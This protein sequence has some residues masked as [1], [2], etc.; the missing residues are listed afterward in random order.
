MG[1]SVSS[2]QN[3]A[4]L[5]RDLE[6]IESVLAGNVNE[7]EV[8]LEKYQA[9]VFTIVSRHVPYDQVEEVAHDTFIQ[10]YKSLP[11]FAAQSPFRFWLSKIAVR[12]CYNFWRVQYK[13]K[14]VPSSSFS[15]DSRNWLDEVMTEPSLE[16]FEREAE[17]QEAKDLLD[18]ALNKVSAADRMV[19]KLIHLEGLSMKEAADQLAWSVAKVK[20]RAHRARKKLHKL[21][22]KLIRDEV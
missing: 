16:S 11:T 2:K 17:R 10:A 8:L 5:K 13:I 15:H 18:W 19:I 20:V 14:E 22:E 6:V 12:S 3:S 1:R 9:Y 21:I 4:D 7:F